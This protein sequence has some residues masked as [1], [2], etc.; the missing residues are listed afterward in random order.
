MPPAFNVDK[1]CTVYVLIALNMLA[2]IYGDESA[3]AQHV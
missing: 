3:C 1:C 2:F